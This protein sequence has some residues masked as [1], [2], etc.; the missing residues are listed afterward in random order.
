MASTI[1]KTNIIAKTVPDATPASSVD[2]HQRNIWLGLFSVC[3]L[4]ITLALPPKWTVRVQYAECIGNSLISFGYCREMRTGWKDLGG[5]HTARF[6]LGCGPGQKCYWTET[7]HFKLLC[8]L[9]TL[10]PCTMDRVRSHFAWVI[11]FLELH[12][13]GVVCF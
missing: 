3:Y 12:G 10:L 6:Y 13:I 7:L 4:R 11:K 8:H 9:E 2:F 1:V 5:T